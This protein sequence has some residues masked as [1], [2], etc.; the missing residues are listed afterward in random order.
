MV[1]ESSK[2]I[3]AVDTALAFVDSIATQEDPTIADL[4]DASGLSRSSVHH[5]VCSL[6]QAGYITR[7]DGSLS[8]GARLMGLGGQCRRELSWF[9][10]VQEQAVELA[11]DVQA[12]V[13]I[14]MVRKKSVMTIYTIHGGEHTGHPWMGFEQP[15]HD[16]AAGHA[17]DIARG[18]DRALE[19]PD[20]MT[21]DN[22][23]VVA[24]TAQL[25]QQPGNHSPEQTTDRVR[26]A[27]AICPTE[28]PLG[29][30]S[31]WTA[32]E[33]GNDTIES[34]KESLNTTV[35]IIEVNVT[36]SGW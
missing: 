4:V 33:E 31:I 29:V 23:I 13:S 32:R 6:E 19:P 20:N 22:S 7:E 17:F 21:V 12:T 24:R 2:T 35:G 36:Y 27:R 26:V 9:P 3:Q 25:K 11:R 14:E 15:L 34:A 10:T 28:S 30:M 8:L 1:S 16:S 18:D 5:Y